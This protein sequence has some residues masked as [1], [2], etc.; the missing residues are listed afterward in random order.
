MNARSGRGDRAINPLG[1]ARLPAHLPRSRSRSATVALRRFRTGQVGPCSPIFAL[2]G[3]GLADRAPDVHVDA[4]L[5]IE[6][7]F[8]ADAQSGTGE[9]GLG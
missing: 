1:K 7:D 5:C 4:M 9:Y 6:H 8:F 3:V 2:R